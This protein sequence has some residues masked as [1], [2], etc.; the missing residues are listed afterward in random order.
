M[1]DEGDAIE[2]SWPGGSVRVHGAERPGVIGM[3]LAGGPDGGIM[4]G[5][6]R[7]GF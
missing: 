1:T 3:S 6:A 5:P 2:L 4:I 7:L